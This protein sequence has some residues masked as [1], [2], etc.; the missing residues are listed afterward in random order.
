VL[1][2]QVLEWSVPVRVR[3]D[4]DSVVVHLTRQ[5]ARAEPFF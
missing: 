5:K 4:R 1:P 3:K 2:D